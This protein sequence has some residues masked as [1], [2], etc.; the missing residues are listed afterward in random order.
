MTPPPR[1]DLSGSLQHLLGR[2]TQE[3]LRRLRAAAHHELTVQVV[4]E[5]SEALLS[6]IQIQHLQR[7]FQGF[8][9]LYT[10]TASTAGGDCSDGDP[11]PCPDRTADRIARFA[12]VCVEAARMPFPVRPAARRATPR[13][14]ATLVRRGFE[15][16]AALLTDS[17][18]DVLRELAQIHAR[19]RGRLEAV[20]R[21]P[22]AAMAG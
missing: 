11:L 2:E 10:G 20:S 13:H 8:A 12:I 1:L 3:C 5:I 4:R 14:L 17:P 22:T 7:H 9:E 21:R 18:D 16:T 19:V 15:R 6:P